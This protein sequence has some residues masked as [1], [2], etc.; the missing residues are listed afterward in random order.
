MNPV[1]TYDQRT[2]FINLTS[3]GDNGVVD[4]L[5][6]STLLGD[7]F[8]M[9]SVV[10]S[11]ADAALE[12]A[13][14][15]PIFADGIAWSRPVNFNGAVQLS[16]TF[17]AT[18]FL[19]I[20][21]KGTAIFQLPLGLKS[22]A[23]RSPSGNVEI[24]TGVNYTRN[25]P[26]VTLFSVG[27][28]LQS[29]AF[30][31]II[32][33]DFNDDGLYDCADVDPLVLEIASGDNNIDFDLTGDRLVN[34]DDLNSWLVEAGA[35]NLPSGLP[36]LPGDASL[37][38]FVDVSDFNIWNSNN[39]YQGTGWCEGNFTADGLTDVSDFN[40]WNANKFATSSASVPEPVVGWQLAWLLAAVWL[41]GKRALMRR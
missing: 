19:P 29:G 36:Y 38:G 25:L 33:G 32:S 11:I 21:A 14:T 22:A 41:P 40:V 20:D 35:A 1:F 23:F 10:L 26:G 7:D 5:D 3:V 6:N 15:L 2:G 13:A 4:S 16:G 8:G 17:I 24:E 30:R 31:M 37:D 34:S 27:D 18:S 39:F 9:I 12:P 28:A